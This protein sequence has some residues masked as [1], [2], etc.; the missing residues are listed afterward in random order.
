[1]R[2]TVYLMFLLLLVCLLFACS[3]KPLDPLDPPSGAPD[4]TPLV[5]EPGEIVVSECWQSDA[6]VVNPRPD[7]AE[8]TPLRFEQIAYAEIYYSNL[9][10]ETG[11][12][13]ADNLNETAALIEKYDLGAEYPSSSFDEVCETVSHVDFEQFRLL[14]FVEYYGGGSMTSWYKLD[15]LLHDGVGKL[16]RMMFTSMEGNW[17]TTEEI[18][19]MARLVL[20]RRE[21]YSVKKEW[22]STDACWYSYPPLVIEAAEPMVSEFWNDAPASTAEAIVYEQLAVIKT[23]L[24]LNNNATVVMD[25]AEAA[26]CV[27]EATLY[28]SEPCR[29]LS[30]IVSHVDFERFAVIFVR[31]NHKEECYEQLELDAIVP[32]ERGDLALHYID[33]RDETTWF[34]Y[35][36][37]DCVRVLVVR[38]SDVEGLLSNK[39]NSVVYVHW[40]DHMIANGTLPPDW[41]PS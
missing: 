31:E 20:V 18:K 15:G 2:K 26:A 23:N 25:L 8:G 34:H 32:R 6:P 19:Y 5:I 37:I 4:Q 16:T 29:Q 14:F 9:S 27:D 12:F 1:M 33:Y 36:E 30:E 35:G 10:I 22:A 40:I 21:D 38:R 28:E 11:L 3:E 17:A 7:K 13:V 41:Q 24:N 39:I